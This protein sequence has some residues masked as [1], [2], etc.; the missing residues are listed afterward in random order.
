[1][2]GVRLYFEV[3][4][5]LTKEQLNCYGDFLKTKVFIT[6]DSKEFIEEINVTDFGCLEEFTIN[7]K[8]Q[9]RKTQPYFLSAIVESKKHE[10]IFPDHEGTFDKVIRVK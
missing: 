6:K 8:T 9:I 7:G 2:N 10:V 3:F 5:P 1:M 4:D